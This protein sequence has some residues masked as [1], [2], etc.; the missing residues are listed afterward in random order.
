M[1]S[2]QISYRNV[3][4]VARKRYLSIYL[5]TL[6]TYC[7]GTRYPVVSLPCRIEYKIWLVHTRWNPNCRRIQMNNAEPVCLHGTRWVAPANR[8]AVFHDKL[9]LIPERLLTVKPQHGTDSLILSVRGKA[10]YALSNS[11]SLSLSC[12]TNSPEQ[13]RA[14]QDGY[15]DI[16]EVTCCMESEIF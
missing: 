7:H 16:H 15:S 5:P 13:T 4:F 8:V 1:P 2:L 3:P 10:A 11:L 12:V 9:K 6:F 14:S